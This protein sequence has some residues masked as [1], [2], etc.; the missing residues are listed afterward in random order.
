MIIGAQMYSVRTMCEN[1]DG[2]RDTLKKLK[3]IGYGSVQVSGFPYDAEKLRAYSE[4]IGIHIGV[5]HTPVDEILNNTDEVIKK[6]K[7]IGADM[8]GIGFPQGYYDYDTKRFDLEKLIRDFTPAVKKL[9]DAG[10]K[11]GYHNHHYE[12]FDQGG[13]CAMDVLIERTDW[14]FILDTGWASHTGADTVA[15]IKKIAPRLQYVH[16]KDFNGPSIVPIYK[17][18][19]PV[20]SIMQAL[21]EAGTKVAYVEQDNAVDK[22]CFEE[23]A[24]SFSGLKAH[25]WT[26]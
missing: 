9:N 3:Q 26:E 8:V 19:I 16:L 21:C 1:E 13:Y 18:N 20:D 22:D 2:I 23:M 7:L 10:L 14:N 6:H 17:G 12:F 4:E 25:G 24:T 15:L 5:T 11:F